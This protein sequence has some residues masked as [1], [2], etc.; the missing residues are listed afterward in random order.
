MPEAGNVK[1]DI[2]NMLGQKIKSVTNAALDAGYHQYI[3]SGKNDFGRDVASGI[4]FYRLQTDNFQS[5]KK[6]LLT[7]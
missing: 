3:W 2:F 1:L 4:Y 6:M 5:V 7:R